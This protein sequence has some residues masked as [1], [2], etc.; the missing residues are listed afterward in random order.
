MYKSGL[1]IHYQHYMSVNNHYQLL[2]SSRVLSVLC[3]LTYLV[4]LI[5][6][7]YYRHFTDEKI[8]V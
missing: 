1:C 6:Y 7:R 5:L 2:C 4:A 3:V 8:E